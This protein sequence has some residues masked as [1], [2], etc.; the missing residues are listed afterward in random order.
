MSTKMTS[1]TE[2]EK[3][4]EMNLTLTQGLLGFEELKEY[5]L[6]RYMENSPFFWFTSLNKTEEG[7]EAKFIV[8]E[9]QYILEDY[10]FDM[11]DADVSEL[12]IVD[13]ADV[14]AFVIVCIPDDP[15]K[16]TANLIGPLVFNYK[17]MKGKQIVLHDSGYPLQ[18]PLFPEEKQ[19]D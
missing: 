13:P 19:L 5:K 8:I 17:N 2:F 10:F 16:M 7:I 15:Q 3:I 11:Q 6:S 1:K 12:E 18:H 14:F 9:P 4:T